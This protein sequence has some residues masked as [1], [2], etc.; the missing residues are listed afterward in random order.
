M[1]NRRNYA[2]FGDLLR[3]T[4]ETA[5]PGIETRVSAADPAEY[6]FRREQEYRADDREDWRNYAASID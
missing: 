3:G 1:N 6:R 2:Y 4:H 5:F